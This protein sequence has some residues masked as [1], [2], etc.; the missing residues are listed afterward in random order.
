MATKNKMPVCF[1]GAIES[2]DDDDDDDDGDDDG[3]DDDDKWRRST[4]F[5]DGQ[6]TRARD[7]GAALSAFSICLGQQRRAKLDS[8]CFCG[9]STSRFKRRV[10]RRGHR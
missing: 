3:D 6:K 2:T 7:C 5:C 9:H 8:S 1:Q 10:W 4:A